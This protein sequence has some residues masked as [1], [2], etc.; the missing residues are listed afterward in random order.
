MTLIFDH[1]VANL[2]THNG[3]AID[4]YNKCVTLNL[5]T[6]KNSYWLRIHAASRFSDI[7]LI[8]YIFLC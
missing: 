4:M 6:R 3:D 5:L 1:R 8:G 2:S 7:I